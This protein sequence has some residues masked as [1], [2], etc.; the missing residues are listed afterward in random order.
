MRERKDLMDYNYDYLF[1]SPSKNYSL[2]RREKDKALVNLRTRT[3][4]NRKIIYFESVDAD[5][6]LLNS[7]LPFD[8]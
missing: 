3:V 1:K 5:V 8:F 7:L 2:F 4:F 6:S